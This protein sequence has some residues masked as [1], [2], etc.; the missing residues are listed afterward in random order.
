MHMIQNKIK[1]FM[2]TRM[3]SILHKGTDYDNAVGGTFKQNKLFTNTNRS[4]QSME[5]DEASIVD[6]TKK[7]DSKVHSGYVTSELD[8]IPVTE[9]TLEVLNLN[10]GY[11]LTILRLIDQFSTLKV[12]GINFSK[13]TPDYYYQMYE[14]LEMILDLMYCKMKKEEQE[15]LQYRLDIIFNTVESM[16]VETDDDMMMDKNKAIR[17]RRDIG[18]LFRDLLTTMEKRGILTYKADNPKMAMG[19]FSD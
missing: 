12:N 11:L 5:K 3:S 14:T 7:A 17:L 10:T 4:A 13:M 19:K 2:P 8:E 9:E 15:N 18:L 16:F 6:R 1:P